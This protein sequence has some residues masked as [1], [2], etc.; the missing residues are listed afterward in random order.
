[1]IQLLYRSV[2]FS[3]LVLLVCTG[4]FAAEIQ[5]SLDVHI[6][7]DIVTVSVEN[8]SAQGVHIETV[9]ITF[10]NNKQIHPYRTN[11]AGQERRSFNFTIP[12]ASLPGTYPLTAA[13]RYMNDGRL[14]SLK[15]VALLDFIEPAVLDAAPVAETATISERGAVTLWA[16]QPE[17]WRLVLPDEVTV[18]SVETASDHRTFM[19]QT[20]VSDFSCSYRYFGVA[21]Q[22]S[23]G[24][25]Y[26][27]LCFGT[28]NT[29]HKEAAGVPRRRGRLPSSA[30]LAQALLFLCA[31]V[32]LL[33][34]RSAPVP[35]APPPGATATSR[36]KGGKRRAAKRAAPA[37]L[38]EPR[39]QAAL[40][41]YSA[42][43][44]FL[45]ALYWGVQ[46]IGGWLD[47]LLPLVSWGPAEYFLTVALA[48]FR[49]SNYEYF[50]TYFADFYWGACLLTTLPY[51]YRFDSDTPLSRDKYVCF[52]RTLLSLGNLFRGKKPVWDYYSRLG[53]LTICVK[54]FFIPYLTS[55]VINN[56]FDQRDLLATFTWDLY[57]V[58]A[59]L[60]AL[61]IYVDTAV[62][63]FGYV[64]EA[65]FLNNRIKSVEPTLLGWVVCLWCYPPFNEFSFKIFDH[66]VFDIAHTYPTWVNGA[67]TCVISILWGIFAWASVALG[68][69]ASNLTN[70]GIVDY[71][72]YRFV[73]HPAYVAKLLIWVI[74]CVF[75]AKFF[76]GM[77][78]GFALIYGLRAWTEERHLSAD[79]DYIAYKRKV[80]WLFVPGLI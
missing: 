14:L 11:M 2:P 50:F 43:M 15:H 12:P 66:Q 29:G 39:L 9:Y 38:P 33:T 58:N 78:L 21:E 53:M 62:Y 19:V 1:M 61:F 79:P 17:L 70:R 42:R 18:E 76:V 28:L 31:S 13:V 68:F 55:W 5:L 26:A 30:L 23:G 57:T 65:S 44:F 67:L 36:K 51:L 64:V 8:N 37:A 16:S 47:A 77:L 4:S 73:R 22:V 41:K 74:Q 52:L 46:N 25:H 71:G 45:T 54:L 3:L 34:K 27:A 24:K 59:F 32:Y 7:G 35:A 75:F 56:T 80:R 20:T 10:D 72:P 60:V 49:G 48:N 69:K 40:T 63:S 6:S